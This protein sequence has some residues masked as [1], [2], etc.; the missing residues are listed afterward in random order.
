MPI[1]QCRRP[2]VLQLF[3]ITGTSLDLH[4]PNTNPNLALDLK[5][6]PNSNTF[7]NPNPTDPTKT[8]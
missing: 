8:Y 3:N 4:I 5:R 6:D 1:F 2:E 7:P